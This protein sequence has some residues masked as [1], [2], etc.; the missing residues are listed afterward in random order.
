MNISIVHNMQMMAESRHL[1]TNSRAEEKATER[2]ASGYRINR[3]ADDAAGLSISEKMRLQ[4]RALKQGTNNAMDG[5]SWVQI[6]D[7]A[8][9]DVHSILHRM[10]ELAIAS[11]NDTNTHADR[12]AMQDEFEQLQ[13]EIDHITDNA[14]F[15]TKHIFDDHE[16]T[17][18]QF[19]GNVKWDYRQAHKITDDNNDLLIKYREKK[20]GPAKEIQIK[21]NNGVYTTQELIDE[22]DDAMFASGLK[23]DGIYLEYTSEG[24]CNV[25][26]EG[27]ETI[28]A[29]TGGLSYL[30]YNMHGGGSLGALIGT[31]VFSTED[32]PL[33]ITNQN[34]KMTFTIEK[35]DG[36]SREVNITLNPGQSYSK[37]E[38]MNE[39]NK[40]LEAQ[41]K[42]EGITVEA[43]NY[44]KS[45]RLASQDC[46][47]SGLKGNMFKIDEGKDVY[48]SVFYDNIKYGTV[49]SQAASLTGGAVLAMRNSSSTQGIDPKYSVFRFDSSNDT[50]VFSPNGSKDPKELKFDHNRTYS[51]YDVQSTL[52]KFFADNNMALSVSATPQTSVYV[53]G[54]NGYVY[55]SGLK[56]TSLRIRNRK[57][58]GN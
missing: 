45:I 33:D 5:V 26:Y 41:L 10:N 27:G 8:L 35:T 57:R 1:K 39:L 21:V 19:E 40:Q 7:A 53:G 47:I 17:Y 38:L 29:V 20:D 23:K 50:L 46:I 12:A 3:A 2:L 51:L 16:A 31:T 42:D 55:F 43:T 22:I 25:N 54:S 52:A 28:D 6:G 34:N 9:E 32:T 18:Y 13:Q 4:I 44:G 15:N 11:V 49:K 14:N 48:T 58:R 56:I 36:S 24:F 30:L 37:T